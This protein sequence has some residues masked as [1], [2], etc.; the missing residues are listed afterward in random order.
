MVRQLRIAIFLKA[1]PFP[2]SERCFWSTL[3][4]QDVH[5]GRFCSLNGCFEERCCQAAFLMVLPDGQDVCSV[6]ANLER[7][8]LSILADYPKIPRLTQCIAYDAAIAPKT[9]AAILVI[10]S[11]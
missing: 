8:S 11:L 10:L 5:I 2:E 6:L 1:H 3:H 9:G 7:D 4:R